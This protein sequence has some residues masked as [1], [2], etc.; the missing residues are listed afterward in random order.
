[1]L[2]ISALS[3]DQVIKILKALAYSFASGF[4]ATLVLQAS[5]FIKAAQTGD[6]AVTQLV[7]ALVAAAVVGGINAVAVAIKQFFTESK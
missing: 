4:V 7:V 6:S 1:M 2:H 3:K 5:D